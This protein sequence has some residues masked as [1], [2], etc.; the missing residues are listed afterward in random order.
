MKKIFFITF[1]SLCSGG[2]FSQNIHIGKQKSTEITFFSDAPLEKIEAKNTTAAPVFNLSTGDFQIRVTMQGFQ[3]KNDLMKEHFNENYVE[4]E[5]YPHCTFKGKCDVT[6]FEEGKTYDVTMTGTMDLHGVSNPVT[7]KGKIRK[8]GNEL[9]MD[10]EFMI[11]PADYK[12]KIPTML[13]E[14]IA[15]D[16]KVTFKSTLEPYVKK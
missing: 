4:S 5:K 16:V 15:E 3:F 7:V 1:L 12:I 10:S 14:K 13:T 2:F 6:N 9:I 8:Q 11:K